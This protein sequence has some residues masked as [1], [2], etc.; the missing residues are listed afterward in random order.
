[1]DKQ[2]S[3]IVASIDELALRGKVSRS[4]A[5][6]AWYAINFYNVDEDD[7]LESAGADGGNDQGIDI[8]FADESSQ[9]IIVLQA[10]CPEN[11]D[12]VTPKAKWDAVV[13]SI[14]IVDN[15]EPL[16]SAGR[17]DLAEDIVKVKIDNPD[18][19]IC[20]GLIS[21]GQR[22]D[23]IDLS[24][25]SF[26][27]HSPYKHYQFIYLAQDDIKSNY[28]AIVDEDAGI[29]EDTF[30]FSG[31]YFQD[32]GEYGRAWIGSVSAM[33]LRRLYQAHKDK[34]FAGNV[35][36]FL[37]AR[38]GGINEQIIRSARETPGT[39]WALNNGITIVAHN[40][41]S[42]DSSNSSIL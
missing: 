9:E 5:F 13:T 30:K 41:N 23:A 4:K 22:S 26:K 27:D 18:Y 31:E 39:F 42:M 24:L 32:S 28:R 36:L 33:E 29:S 35:R 16:K 12:K 8:V 20:F 3:D 25:N 2:L 14:P 38:K 34:L 6:A 37:G 17:L 7:A 11:M 10:H 15:P 21:L 1:M 19:T 40:A